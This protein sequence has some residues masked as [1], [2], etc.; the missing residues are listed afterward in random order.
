MEQK[1]LIDNDPYLQRGRETD[2]AETLDDVM[3]DT[4]KTIT[5][6]RLGIVRTAKIQVR[7]ALTAIKLGSYGK[8][9][10]CGKDI[11]KA[12]LE[13]YPEATTCIECAT[14]QSQMIDVHED[15]ILEKNI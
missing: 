6:A 7:K 1:A 15:E 5:D 2:N 3:E 14:D 11:D 13:V 8:C 9:E 12:R 10:V 4:G